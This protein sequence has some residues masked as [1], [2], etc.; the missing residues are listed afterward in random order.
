MGKF[1]NMVDFNKPKNK[2]VDFRIDDAWK[3]LW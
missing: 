1:M 2:P 3:E